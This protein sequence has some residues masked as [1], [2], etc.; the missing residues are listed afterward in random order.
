MNRNPEPIGWSSFA[1]R[2]ARE[3][4]LAYVDMQEVDPMGEDLTQAIAEAAG[5]FVGEVWG[6]MFVR[7]HVE[8]DYSAPLIWEALVDVKGAP[9]LTHGQVVEKM[10][11][12]AS[13]LNIYM[14]PAALFDIMAA[15]ARMTEA[16]AEDEDI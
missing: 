11:R 6:A 4:L 5:L 12:D 3:A 16:E 2:T 14:R 15:A 7:V 1:R 13:R 9:T 8:H 10:P